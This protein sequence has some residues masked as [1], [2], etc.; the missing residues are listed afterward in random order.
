MLTIDLEPELEDTLKNI[1]KQARISPSDIIKQ[2][3]S[4]YINQKQ[5]DEKT[6][7]AKLDLASLM[8]NVPS[9][10]SLV[11]ELIQERRQ[12]AQRIE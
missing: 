7:Q 12:E 5:A 1:A 6:Q 3:V 4:Q 11:D 9:S 2:L 8:A 10:V